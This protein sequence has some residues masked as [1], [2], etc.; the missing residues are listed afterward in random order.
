MVDRSWRAP[1]Y[2]SDQA[3]VIDGSHTA[4][5]GHLPGP[6]GVSTVTMPDLSTWQVDHANPAVLVG[7]DLFD[8]DPTTSPLLLTAFGGDEVL[9]I[10][11]DAARAGDDGA[12][13]E[14]QANRPGPAVGPQTRRSMAPQQAGR[15]ILLADLSEDP[16]L[17]PLARLAAAL[18]GSN[19]LATGRGPAVLESLART[20]FE[21]AARLAN[22]VDGDDL[23]WLGQTSSH[24]LREAL[25][26]AREAHAAEFFGGSGLAAGLERLRSEL[27]RSISFDVVASRIA[28]DSDSG[29]AAGLLESE[30]SAAAGPAMR[31]QTL[32]E[33]DQVD[34][35]R[36]HESLVEVTVSRDSKRRW[37]ELLRRDGSRSSTIRRDR[38]TRCVKRS[39]QGAR[40]PARIGWGTSRSPAP[41]GSAAPSSGGVPA[42]RTEP[43][44]HTDFPGWQGLRPPGVSWRRTGWPRTSPNTS[45]RKSGP[46]CPISGPGHSYGSKAVGRQCAAAAS[47]EDVMTNPNPPKESRAEVPTPI[48]HLYVLL[49]RSGSMASIADDVIGGFNQLLAEQKADGSDARMTLVQFDT[50][51]AH[52]V[53]ADAVPIREVLPLDAGT[54]VPRGGTPLLDA[55]GLLLTRA[56]QR[57]GSL[58]T[59]GEPAEE[60]VF[61]SITDG[62]ENS[63][64]ELDLG[65]VRNLVD[66]HTKQGW[67]FVFLSAALD[68]YAEAGGIGMDV[69][70]TQAFA[71]DS[72]GTQAA[73]A[74]LSRKTADRRRKVRQRESFDK[75]DFFED[76]KPAEEDRRRRGA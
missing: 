30:L 54:F 11:E 38:S 61:V 21:S 67:T 47:E 46:V 12:L 72:A 51:D 28:D 13:T 55:T 36:T 34:F 17:H 43:T 27:D 24:L 32:E 71:Q 58:A 19:E 66:R 29:A 60:I 57:V 15:L 39:P 45:E 6:A 76:D 56:A 9:F 48:V 33:R 18:Q 23:G 4:V 37:A 22:E 69:R 52:E 63:S 35:R 20:L 16:N 10:L 14:V 65:T 44:W 70:S 59:S 68:V 31:A 53:I 42:T 1:V 62:H 8:L 2:T 7:M 75:D 64:R 50:Q 74:S 3:V 41:G 26:T 5:L 40:R 73:F 49:D 25:S